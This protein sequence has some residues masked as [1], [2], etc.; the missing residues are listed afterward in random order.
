MYVI[1]LMVGWGTVA[2]WELPRPRRTVESLRQMPGIDT[3]SLTVVARPNKRTVP[4]AV[5]G[6]KGGPTLVWRIP[7]TFPSP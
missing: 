1:L 3:G 7:L 2:P 4:S 5:L 6:E